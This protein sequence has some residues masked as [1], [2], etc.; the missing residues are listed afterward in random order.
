MFWLDRSGKTRKTEVTGW[1]SGLRQGHWG[2]YGNWVM[3]NL[4]P[5]TQEV[6]VS[7]E[8]VYMGDGEYW[9]WHIRWS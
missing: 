4:N 8:A 1:K 5:L 9:T 2:K 7:D 3:F 6:V